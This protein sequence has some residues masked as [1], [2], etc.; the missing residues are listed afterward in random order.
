MMISG[1]EVIAGGVSDVKEFTAVLLH[2]EGELTGFVRPLY[3][4]L[5]GYLA[6]C[7]LALSLLAILQ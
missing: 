2:P 5:D 6:F 3:L 7:L 4:Y 1:S